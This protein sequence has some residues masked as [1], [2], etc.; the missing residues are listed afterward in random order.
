VVV[1]PNAYGAEGQK[2]WNAGS[3]CA[4]AA[5]KEVDDMAF[6]KEVMDT[7]VKD[8]NVD[9]DQI[10]VAGHSNGGGMTSRIGCEF[11]DR[12]RGTVVFMGFF[13]LKDFEKVGTEG[14]TGVDSG[15]G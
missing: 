9:P 5:F 1:H 13:G 14:Q 2:S 15:M 12:V 6:I 7:M 11:G 3:C 8:Y 4:T 10:F